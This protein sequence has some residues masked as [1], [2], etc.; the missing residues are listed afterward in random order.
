MST[1]PYAPPKAPVEDR[2]QADHAPALWNPNAAA[3]W[4]L[5]FSPIFGAALHMLNWQALGE[6]QKAAESKMWL[7]TCIGFFVLL[8]IAS[9]LLPES[10]LMDAASRAGGF[11]LLLA[12][13]FQNAR[14]Q[15]RYVAER[16]GTTYPRRGW[17]K[18]ILYTFLVLFG[19]FV[20]MFVIVLVTGTGSDLPA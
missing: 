9:A 6:P 5:L 12:W 13:Y 3:G 1:N 11:A 17:G 18:P 4:S 10:K 7:Y 19:L 8:M 20:V 16:F 14:P 2:H 15:A